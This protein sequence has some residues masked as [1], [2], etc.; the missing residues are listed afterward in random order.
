MFFSCNQDDDLKNR[1]QVS[2]LQLDKSIVQVNVTNVATGLQSVFNTMT[3]DSITRAKL[4][5]FFVDSARFF[6]DHSGYFFIE[7]YNDAW[8]VAHANESWIGTKRI[9]AQDAHGKY[10]VKELAATA[11]NIGYG[12][13]EYYFNNPAS[14]NN[15]RKLAFVMGMPSVEWFIGAGFYGEPKDIY[16]DQNDA[17][18]MIVEETTRTVAKGLSGIFTNWPTDE[19]D[20]VIFCRNFI[21]HI[22]FFDDQSG[23]F[24]IYNFEGV[25]VAHGI[26]KDLQG[27]NLWDY[28]DTKGN[29]VIR[30]LANIAE[31]E[32]EGYYQ[33]YWNNPIT[34][35]EEP[36]TAFVI[37]I[38]G[39]NYFIGSGVYLED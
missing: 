1:N 39:T 31:N 21:N 3:N 27:N 2:Q 6:N 16:Y 17:N 35:K 36:K 19:L 4:C 7:T 22:R 33:Y 14:G 30:E 23:Y 18:K 12:F 32:G 37:K 8:V 26:Q 11:Q 13:V 25:N 15:E 24:F 28:Q 5:Q 29:Y 20:Q 10:H 34:S 38:P 9:N